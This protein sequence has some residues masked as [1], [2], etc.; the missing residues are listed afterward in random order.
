MRSK[1][2]L[3]SAP[4]VD[5]GAL[6][7]R[8][9]E[10]SIDRFVKF[11][12]P[13]QK[14]I[15][16]KPRREHLATFLR[17]L[18]SDLERK[19][20]EPI[21]VSQGFGRYDLQHFVGRSQWDERPLLRHLR[22]EV[23][24]E[25]GDADG[26]FVV[27]SSGV[28]KSGKDSVGVARQWCGRLGKVENCQVGVYVAYSAKGSSTLVDRRLYLPKSWADD[29]GRR[30]KVHVPKQVRF[31]K[32]WKLALEMLRNC[33][34]EI[35]GGWVAADEEFGRPK[36]FRDGVAA[37]GLRYLVEVPSNIV[38]RKRRG[39][40]SGRPPTWHRLSKFVKQIPWTEWRRFKLRD[41]DKGPV[42]VRAVMLRV[43]TRRRRTRTKQEVL[44]VI[45]TLDGSKRW[46]FLT[47]ASY[48][49]P[50]EKLIEIAAQRNLIEQA[51]YLGKGAVGLDHYEVRTWQGWHHHTGCA[52]IA[53]WFLVR[54]QRRLG[55]KAP[56]LTAQLVKFLVSEALRPKLTKTDI[57]CLCIYQLRRNE[58][59]RQA[60]WAA[61][62]LAAPPKRRAA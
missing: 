22:A 35:R 24:A 54:E 44:L 18:V 40:G 43:E 16:L 29:P 46:C 53:Q 30:S 55:K 23:G 21:A 25:L 13:Y 10:G 5:V 59:A 39:K 26:V 51:F 28:P 42:E 17:G 31:R 3:R 15:G 4:E 14:A 60:R 12:E 27:D 36:K 8:D 34:K 61:R 7:A 32:P 48:R 11:I 33:R 52:L 47:N 1:E 9:V 38:V 62:G 45:E 57:A 37:L 20:V 56:P 50:I 6:T 19:S 49:T 2:V 58:A 41:S